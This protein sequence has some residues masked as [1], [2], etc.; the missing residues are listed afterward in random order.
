ML[1]EE[2]MTAET[3]DFKASGGDALLD[4][5]APGLRSDLHAIRRIS[6]RTGVN[7]VTSKGLYMEDSWPV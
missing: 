6:E 3:A 7:V 2:V 1:D 4:M 5:S